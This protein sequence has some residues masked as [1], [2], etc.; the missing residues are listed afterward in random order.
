MNLTPEE[1]AIGQENYH[2]AVGYTRRD[3]LKGALAAG[4]GTAAAS[5]AM[6]FGY[7]PQLSDPVR[8]GIIGTG[9]E[10]N[11]LI[12]SINPRYLQVVAISDIRPSSI[13]RA[14]HGDWSGSRPQDTAAL[15]PGLMG[16]YG[17]QTEQA[18]RQHVRVYE[19]Y[20]ELIEDPAVE[21]VIIA[22][23]L[24]L[25]AQAAIRA[26]NAGKHVLTEKLMAHNVAQCKLMARVA[27]DRNV[28]LATGHQRHY[29]ILYDNAVHLLQWGLLGEIHHV[30]AQWHRGNLPGQD[31]WK[32]PLPGGEVALLDDP[33][34]KIKK[35]E[36]YDPIA[37]QL[38][39]F[40]DQL[41]QASDPS[42]IEVL[43][44]QIA[45]WAAWDSDKQ[46]DAGRFGYTELTLPDRTR[47][48]LEEL[49]RWRLWDRTGGGLMAEL[50]SHQLDAASIFISALRRD[51]RRAHPL[52]VHAVGG[53]HL[54]PFDRQSDDHV[55][56]MY[57]FP[58]PG[59]EPDFDV[60]YRDVVSGVPDPASG[61]PAY[62]PEQHASK[63][64]VVTYSS[65]NGNGFGGYGEVVLGTKGTLIVEGEADAMLYAGSSTMTKV[66]VKDDGGGATL[67]TQAS[68]DYAAVSRAA[69]GGPVSRGYREEMEHWAWC[70]RNAAPE[71]QP[72]CHPQVALGDAVIALATN[73]AMRNAN[74]GRGGFLKFDPAWFDIERDDT[75]DGSSIQEE[76]SE[77]S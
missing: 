58:A 26:M 40:Q 53:R 55:Y 4:V 30:R 13:H 51:N 3:F 25:H 57:E 34:R 77:M 69:A 52:T 41:S 50:G 45:Q 74:E 29:S 59:Y 48:A 54:F 36:R 49:V 19:R 11:I 10:G 63:K 44:K 18:A 65:V 20:E 38:Q 62:D 67:D 42:A 31:S 28:Y 12:G 39:R 8:V 21:A 9:D 16:V 46:V 70:I 47:G 73:V 33:E 1:K 75:P 6:Y 15:R 72:K 66:G 17:W 23:P 27:R 5:G 32:P 35:G 68:G 56:C 24:H 22:L 71:N 61:V 14:L 60:G 43:Q 2:A 37:E 64:I 76:D 7:D